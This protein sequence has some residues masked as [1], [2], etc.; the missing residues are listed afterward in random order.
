[1]RLDQNAGARNLGKKTLSKLVEFL[2]SNLK[3]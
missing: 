3:F 1:M 2:I